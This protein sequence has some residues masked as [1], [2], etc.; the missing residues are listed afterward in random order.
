MARFF[1]SRQRERTGMLRRTMQLSPSC[2]R[3]WQAALRG[4]IWNLVVAGACWTLAGPWTTPASGQTAVTPYPRGGVGITGA[5]TTEAEGVDVQADRLSYDATRRLVL[6]R[7]NVRV[8]RGTDWIVADE[9]DVDNIHQIVVAHGNI[10]LHY[11]ENVWRGENVTYNFRTGQGDFGNF[12]LFTPPFH[13]TAQDSRRVSPSVTEL[14]GV[15][16]TTC[17]LEDSVNGSPEYSIRAS[18]ASILSNR[19]IR[20]RNVR[21]HYGA[22]PFFWFPYVRGDANDFASFEFLPG[23]SSKWGVFL[24]S[25]YNYPLTESLKSRTSFDVRSKRG[26]GIGE[27]LIWEDPADT[28]EGALRLYYIHDNKP[29]RNDSQKQK[30]EALIDEERYRIQ[31]KD[32]SSITDRD[33]FYT[34]LNY[35]SDPWMLKDFFEDEYQHGMQPENRASLSHRGDLYTAGL[36][37]NMR[38]NDFYGNVNRLPEAFLNFNR[39]QVFGSPFYYQGE[40]TVSY[41]DRVFADD[42]KDETP[43]RDDY[44]AFRMDTSH[45]LYLPLRMG[46]LSLV[47]RAGY[48]GTFY[49]KTKLTTIVT[50]MVSSTDETTGLT[51]VSEKTETILDDGDAEWRSLPELGF[52][53]SFKA[54]GELLQGPIGI[55]EDHGLRH[56]FE[57]YAKYTFRPEPDLTPDELWYFDAIDKLSN[58]NDVD[59]GIRNYLQT[60][61]SGKKLA[62]IRD[63]IYL[64]TFATLNLDPD[65]EKD[66]E[67]FRSFTAEL[68]LKPFTGVSWNTEMVYDNYT[69]EVSDLNTTLRIRKTEL[70]WFA[71][72][73]RY[74][75]NKREQVSVDLTLFPET[76]WEGRVY[77]RYDLEESHLDE[78]SV[79]FIHR[80]NCLGFGL[81]VRIR[82]DYDDDGEDDYTIW[83]QVWPLAFPSF[84]GHMPDSGA[85]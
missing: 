36:Q 5:P 20:A 27:D 50:N 49:S 62:D 84:M 72:Q 33:T 21:F 52:E 39:Q 14:E 6:A 80:T 73:Y 12:E 82:P 68:E 8:S 78:Y 32:R 76:H 83:A 81:G 4:C 19:I 23:F 63:L 2:R 17:D 45:M 25:A 85:R 56:V 77:G 69:N 30:R 79:Y 34:T 55:E 11:G 28:Y 13:I 37:L 18:S 40:N 58:T 74:K 46:F 3:R 48:R 43:Q 61:I 15:L 57:P 29:W 65:D 24:L 59:I 47:P 54:F 64:D 60:K 42:G 35:L 1:I 7:G 41:L 9:A 70:I 44:D 31:L 67:T 22:I 53:T 38:L 75:L 26:I 66:E 10:E 71:T 16:L 51:T